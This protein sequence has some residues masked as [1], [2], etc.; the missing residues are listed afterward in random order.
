MFCN[1]E[2]RTSEHGHGVTREANPTGP[3]LAPTP[4]GVRPWSSFS[5]TSSRPIIRTSSI[6]TGAYLWA[7]RA[8]YLE[9]RTH[10]PGTDQQT[11]LEARFANLTA[12]LIPDTAGGAT[13]P[14]T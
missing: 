7:D 12:L 1:C 10:L 9:Q 6:G 13:H 5:L 2:N 3:G 11:C 8:I 4:D 14:W